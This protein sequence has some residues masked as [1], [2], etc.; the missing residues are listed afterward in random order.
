MAHAKQPLS[1]A[2]EFARK[3]EAKSGGAL[4]DFWYFLR[5]SKKWWLTPIIISLLLLGALVVLAGTGAAPF[6]YTLF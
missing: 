5:H 2:D 6:I 4:S 3:A 1:A